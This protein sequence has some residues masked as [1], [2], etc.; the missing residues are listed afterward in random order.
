MTMYVVDISSCTGVGTLDTLI[1][2]PNRI[3]WSTETVAV[4]T[5]PRRG[6]TDS[7]NLT[8]FTQRLL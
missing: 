4:E 5:K 7:P 3:N 1:E 8:Y 2:E 6:Q